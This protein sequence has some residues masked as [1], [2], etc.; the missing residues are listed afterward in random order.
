LS[1][2]ENGKPWALDFIL[3]G[4][5]WG[6]SF[7]FMR[8]G[9]VEFGPFA[10]AGVRVA[11][12]SAFLLPFLLYK[13]LGP[14]LLLHWKH[15]FFVGVLNSAIPFVCFSFALLSISTGL[16]SMLNA[17]VPLFGALVAWFWLHDKPT[18]TRTLGLLVGFM[19]A[20]MLAWDQAGVKAGAS[21]I[22]P[23]WGVLAGLL[24]CACYAVS[25]SYTRRFLADVPALVIATGSQ[26]GAMLSLALPAL[27][28]RPMHMPS[29]SAW[30][31]LLAVGV[32]SSGIAYILFFR[33]IANTGPARAL[34]VSYVVPVFAVLYGLIFLGEQVTPWMLLCGAVIVL[35]TA[36][37]TG[38]L[39]LKPR[40]FSP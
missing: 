12:A 1:R 21:G 20:A 15:V 28:F 26:I 32:I 19:G 29:L 2:A 18:R 37:S 27:W 10:T 7:L 31:A 30:L 36:L 39:R 35:G 33:L 4:A 14:S 3:L 40:H 5:V 16:S 34:S 9:V 13:G 8:I 38:L 22:A 24:A 23:I 11:I 17:T 25:A 6:A